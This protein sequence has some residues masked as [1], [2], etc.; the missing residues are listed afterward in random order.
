MTARKFRAW[1][2]IEKR[3]LSQEEMN[4]TGG[5]YYNHGVDPKPDDYDLQQF[6]WLFDRDGKE[7]FEGDIVEYNSAIDG[8]RHKTTI[9]NLSNFRWFGNLSGK[10]DFLLISNNYEDQSI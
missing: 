1:S 6:V 10:E 8:E 7:L 9:P 3:F 2:K 4:E 5:F